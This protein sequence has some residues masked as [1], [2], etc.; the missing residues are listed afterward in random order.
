MSKLALFHTAEANRVLFSDLL[1]RLSPHTDAVHEVG[2]DLL[3]R[4]V[5]V[6]ELAED[7]RRDSA[8][9]IT[10]FAASS[11]AEVILCTC[12]TLG[13]AAEDAGALRV[14]RPMAEQALAAAERGRGRIGVL[15]C[16]ASTLDPTLDL[17][18]AVAAETGGTADLTTRLLPDAWALFEA[19]DQR[20][21]WRAVAEAVGG[22]AAEVDAVVLAQASMAGAAALCQDS[23]VPVLM[24]WTAPATGIAMCQSADAE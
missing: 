10:D 4:A 1:R 7:V 9:R 17:L 18:R 3:A 13:P 24:R 14:D 19:G 12:S 11:G 5:A 2:A 21:Y 20:A 22:I 6:G 8:R 16:L 23:G 15:A